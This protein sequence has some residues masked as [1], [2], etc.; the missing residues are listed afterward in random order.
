MIFLQAQVPKDW[1]IHMHC[2][3][4]NWET[5]QHWMSN[6]PKMKFGFVPDR[7]F[8]EVVKKIPLEKVLLETDAP[9]FFPTYFKRVS[10][11]CNIFILFLSYDFSNRT[12]T[13]E[14]RQIRIQ[15]LSFT[16]RLKLPWKRIS[17][18][19]TFSMQIEET[20]K[21]FMVFKPLAR[22]LMYFSIILL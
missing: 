3:T 7:F 6:W 12:M 22:F 8:G 10:I 14:T 18:W 15:V 5:C 20:S 2:F 21:K 9:Y 1:K 4:Y 19:T 11:Y 16:L 17:Q 13:M